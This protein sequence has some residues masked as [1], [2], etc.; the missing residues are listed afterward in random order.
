MSSY[1]FM[2]HQELDK[3][4]AFKISWDNEIITIYHYYQKPA[5]LDEQRVKSHTYQRKHIFM[6]SNENN[7]TIIANYLLCEK[8]LP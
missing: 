4:G 1:F 2:R 7:S 3:Y 5:T 6:H 8:N